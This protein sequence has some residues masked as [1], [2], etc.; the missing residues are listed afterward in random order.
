[1]GSRRMGREQG[2]RARR[3]YSCHDDDDDDDEIGLGGCDTLVV[4]VVFGC[5]V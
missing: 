1:M 3:Y 4:F 2:G 5:C